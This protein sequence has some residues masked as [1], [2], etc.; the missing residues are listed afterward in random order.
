MRRRVAQFVAFTA[1]CLLNGKP[2]VWAQKADCPS[3]S[4]FASENRQSTHSEI[5]IAGVTFSGFIQLPISDQDQ[6]ASSIKQQS[7][8]DSLEG[9]IEEALERVRT[10]WQDRGYFKVEVSGDASTLTST[11]NS[12]RI[13]LDAHVDEGL[14]YKLA[15][16][17]FKHNRAISNNKAL[18][19][20]FPIRDG[21]I[22]SREKIAAGLENLRKAYGEYG[23]INYTGVPGTTFNDERKLAFLNIDVDEGK[24]FFVSSINVTGL[25]ESARQ[26]LL[27][28]LLVKPG[29]IFNGRLWELSLL[30]HAS[31][32]SMFP[33]CTCRNSEQKQLDERSGTVAIA[34]DFRPC[35]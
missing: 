24:Q 5:S 12:Q 29:Q 1:V 28:D 3:D 26:A 15:R 34:L 35:P 18:R 11:P 6:I 16:I 20:L 21:E 30:K 31:M 2:H 17:T 32:F 10:G 23:Y 4:A 13:L 8:G 33:K 7:H 22:F 25:D 14:R 9:V 19:A 27:N